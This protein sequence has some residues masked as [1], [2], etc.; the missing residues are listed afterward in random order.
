[1]QS[2]KDTIV[3]QIVFQLQDLCEKK[4]DMVH[5]VL[6]GPPGCGKTTLGRIMAKIYLKMG[7]VS[8]DYFR[9]VK[10]PD[11]VGEYLGQ[12]A[13]KTQKVFDDCRGGV[14]FIDEAYSLG[15]SEKR[16]SF[17]KECIDLINQNLSEMKGEIVCIIAGYRE[18]LSKCFFAYN[19]GLERRFPFRHNIDPYGAKEL[20]E[21]FMKM[22]REFGW[23]FADSEKDCP[24]K[25]FTDKKECFKF[26]GGDMET[27]FQMTKITHAK[28]VF[29]S[30]EGSERKKISRGDLE[31]AFD[32]F[33]V[34]NKEA[35]RV[36][37]RTD[38]L[39]ELNERLMMGSEDI[40]SKV[41]EKESDKTSCNAM[42]I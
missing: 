4:D 13:V 37:D 21:I 31:K 15:N 16:D 25:F 35:K 10:R 33:K 40:R 7:L 6:Y 38:M 22:V 8:R 26:S 41:V 1:M 19:P 28:R 18:N 9:I 14:L 24:I 3:D 32:K 11:L 34:K 20:R 42:Y 23:G 27:L 36:S 5:T 29:C 12:T 17:S 30:K 2:V 39:N